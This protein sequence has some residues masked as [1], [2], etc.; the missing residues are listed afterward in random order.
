[1]TPVL[2]RRILS[3]AVVAAAILALVTTGCGRRE[4]APVPKPE[5][6]PRIEM[7]APDFRPYGC[8]GVELLVNSEASVSS[9][10]ADDGNGRWIDVAYPG[11]TD[12]RIYLSLTSAG[13]GVELQ[14]ALA[15]RHE[16]MELNSA[17]ART[18]II[19]LTS[20]AGWECELALTRSSVT[21]PVQLLAHDGAG[22]MLSGALYLNLP[23]GTP[24][25]SIAPVV[26]AVSRDLT[27]MLKHL[28]DR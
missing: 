21:T 22:R 9:R 20:E 1:M 16:R 18:E 3:P 6:W 7:P 17:G 13:S 14:R 26:E 4:S 24:P 10:E 12:A 28:R 8:G 25:D 15:N 2:F 19:Q 11:I 27:E 5:G 23:P